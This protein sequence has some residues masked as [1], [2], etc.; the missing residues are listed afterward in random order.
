VHDPVLDELGATAAGAVNVQVTGVS[1]ALEAV[2]VTVAPGIRFDT[3]NSGRP[4]DVTPSPAVPVSELEARAITGGATTDHSRRSEVAL[5]ATSVATIV[6][7][8]A[9]DDSEVSVAGHAVAAAPLSE[10]V[11][12]TAWAS[13]LVGAASVSVVAVD[14][15]SSPSSNTSATELADRAASRLL[16]AVESMVTEAAGLDDDHPV[17]KP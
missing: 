4:W 6:R 14:A 5:P 12:V 10:H 11:Y 2:T 17:P 9:P 1:P 8:L 3:S 13:V 15:V 7:E 16:G